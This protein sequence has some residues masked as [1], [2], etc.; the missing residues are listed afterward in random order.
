MKYKLINSVTKKETIC[1]KVTIDEF[2]YY[3]SDEQ[4]VKGWYYD[5][6]INKIRNT[7]GADYAENEITK[8]VIATTNPNIDVPKVMD[9]VENLSKS[10]VEKIY[11]KYIP[12]DL[13]EDYIVLYKLGYNKSQ[14]T[15]PFSEDDMI[16]FAEWIRIKD[17][18]TASKDRWIGLNMQYYTT[19]E[20]LQLW[21]EQQPKIVYYE[22]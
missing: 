6:F 17:F 16:E 14:E 11:S 21:K 20:L 3:V 2:D 15:H 18:Q 4:P 12:K 9:E 5:A 22:N 10:N 7:N 19:K 8:Q 13:L 1:D